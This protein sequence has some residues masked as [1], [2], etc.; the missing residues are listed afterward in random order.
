MRGS[1]KMRFEYAVFLLN[2]DVEQIM[3]TVGLG[4]KNLRQTLAN[5]QLIYSRLEMI[6]A[7]ALD[8]TSNA[9][10]LVNWHHLP[11]IPHSY[12]EVTGSEFTSL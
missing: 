2:K 11:I 3:N 7:K 10:Q 1:D 12:S 8:T 4:V 6:C 9:N 5:I